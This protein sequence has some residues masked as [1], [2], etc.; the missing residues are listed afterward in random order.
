VG[1]LATIADRAD[2]RRVR[3]PAVIVVGDVVRLA[4]RW[5]AD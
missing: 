1:T 2:E 4:D 5:S 3:P